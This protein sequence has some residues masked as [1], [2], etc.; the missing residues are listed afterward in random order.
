MSS[1]RSFIQKSAA[2]GAAS[3]VLPN[4]ALGQ[5]LGK[6]KNSANDK[7]QIGI[8][9]VGLRGTNHLEMPLKGKM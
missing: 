7:L 8:I 1:R 2:F 9:G 4:L 3:V 5:S 6:A